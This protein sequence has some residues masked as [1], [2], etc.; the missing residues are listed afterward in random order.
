MKLKQLKKGDFFTKKKIDFPK[1]NQVW[2]RSDYD[3]VERKY[4]CY[5]FSDVNDFCFIDGNKEIFTDFTF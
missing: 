5:R 2:I 1:D 4:L 3:R